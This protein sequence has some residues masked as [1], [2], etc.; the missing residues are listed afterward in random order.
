LFEWSQVIKNDYDQKNSLVQDC[1]D[2]TILQVVQAQSVM[3]N[4]LAKSHFD[5]KAENRRLNNSVESLEITVKN[6]PKIIAES[7]AVAFIDLLVQRG[8]ISTTTVV[9]SPLVQRG[10][11]ST[12]TVVE[13]PTSDET[14]AKTSPPN[15]D[16]VPSKDELN[17]IIQNFRRNLEELEEKK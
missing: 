5:L 10:L 7:M 8:L 3:I 15:E 17:D 2:T 6:Q 12:T 13:S 4:N 1:K 14:Q 9:E 16:M 11:I